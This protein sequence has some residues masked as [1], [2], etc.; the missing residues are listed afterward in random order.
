MTP[1]VSPTI[2]FHA[3]QAVERRVPNLYMAMFHGENE[4]AVHAHCGCCSNDF[5][6]VFFSLSLGNP[7]RASQGHRPRQT[8]PTDLLTDLTDTVAESYMISL[9]AIRRSRRQGK[10][11]ENSST[12]WEL[13]AFVPTINL[14]FLLGMEA[15]APA[16]TAGWPRCTGAT[17]FYRGLQGLQ[18]LTGITGTG[19]G[20]HGG[21]GLQGPQGHMDSRGPFGVGL[22][23]LKRPL[24]AS[25]ISMDP[26]LLDRLP[27]RGVNLLTN[28]QYGPSSGTSNS[29]I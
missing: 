1:G 6:L 23:A 17:G 13:R 19:H 25:V 8:D 9:L 26:H 7:S 24:R 22:V 15:R 10:K 27:T 14:F 28:R 4:R 21:H 16:L 20:G 2:T 11:R 18:R 5:R 29:I 12:R 3:K